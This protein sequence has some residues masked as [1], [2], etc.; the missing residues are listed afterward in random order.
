MKAAY[1]IFKT[2]HLG[3]AK[4]LFYLKKVV[5]LIKHTLNYSLISL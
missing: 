2:E 4:T 3:L 1:L 5:L